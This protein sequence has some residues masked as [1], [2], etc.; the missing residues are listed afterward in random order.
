MSMLDDEYCSGSDI[1]PCEFCGEPFPFE[2]IIEHQTG[3]EP[4]LLQYHFLEDSPSVPAAVASAKSIP[5]SKPQGTLD[6]I[7]KNSPTKNNKNDNKVD[8]FEKLLKDD[9]PVI[10][11]DINTQESGI[12]LMS[13]GSSVAKRTEEEKPSFRAPPLPLLNNADQ[14]ESENATNSLS[15]SDEDEC[16][17]DFWRRAEIKNAQRL[18][19]LKV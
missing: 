18:R 19:K 11:E 13:Y 14:K 15:D 4:E 10:Y 16:L 7:E 6:T 9:I 8:P 12:K 2:L 5:L 3:C 1:I 17:E